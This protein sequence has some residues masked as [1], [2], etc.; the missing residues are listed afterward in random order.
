M[1]ASQIAA[2]RAGEDEERDAERDEDVAEAPPDQ[3][4]RG[5]SPER[6]RRS[7]TRGPSGARGPPSSGSAGRRLKTSS[8]E[9]DR[10]RARRGRRRR[11]RERAA[12]AGSTRK[13]T[14]RTSETSGPAIAIRNSAPALGNMPLNFATPP[15]SQSVIPSISIPSRRAW[16]AWPNSCRRSDVKKRSAGDDRH[17]DVGAVGEAGVASRGRCAVASVH[18]ISAKTISQ[19]QLMPN[20]DA[21]DAADRDAVA[22]GLYGRLRDSAHGLGRRAWRRGPVLPHRFHRPR[23][24]G[25]CLLPGSRR[26]DRAALRGRNAVPRPVHLHRDQ[27]DLE[28]GH[29][30]SKTT[31]PGGV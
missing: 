16:S 27:H 30:L 6:S 17:R 28:G 25:S 3:R 15:K 18:A 26:E 31:R 22:H 9:V 1:K 4:R 14:P 29:R 21:G 19:L 10:S 23:T 2:H 24:V 7:R 8:I 5:G 13:R 11:R 20:A 12:A